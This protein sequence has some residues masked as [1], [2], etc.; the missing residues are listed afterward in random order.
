[1]KDINVRKFLKLDKMNVLICLS[2]CFVY[3][4][5]TLLLL[6]NISKASL[7]IC[8]LFLIVNLIRIPFSKNIFK[9]YGFLLF[10][11]ISIF[12]FAISQLI[13]NEK[14]MMLDIQ[15]IVA[16]VLCVNILMMF[17]YIVYPNFKFAIASS[18]LLIM[19]ITT[20]NYFVYNFRG[21]EFALND[22]LTIQTTI[23]VIGQYKFS[24]DAPF[25]YAWSIYL[26]MANVIFL[27]PNQV[28]KTSLKKKLMHF[29]YE[30]LLI[31]SL[32]IAS[33][34]ITALHFLKTGAANNGYILNFILQ[35]KETFV[36][37]P[38]NYDIGLIEK[39]EEQFQNNIDTLSSNPNLIVIMNESFADFR[40]LGD[41][42]KTNKDV[43]P[44]LDSLNK[45]TIKGYALS[46]IYGG[47]TPNSEYEFLTGNSMAF[48]PQGSIV[49]Q[50]FLKKNSYSMVDS[51][52]ELGYE[53]FATHPYYSSGW[54]RTSVYNYLGFEDFTFIDDYPQENL[55][56][57]FVSDQEMY[58][59]IIDK[60]ESS[61]AGNKF[62]FGI[63]MQNHGSY[64][65]AGDNFNQTIELEGYSQEYPDVEQYLS[66]IHE[67]DKALE[68]L[69][70]YFDNKDEP[71]VIVFYG[72]HFPSLNNSFYEEVHGSSFD[73]LDE[74]MLQYKVPFLIWANYDIEEEYVECTSLN[75]LSNYMFKAANM[76]LPAYN[77]YL[78][79]L[80]EEISAINAY[81][82]YS[83][84]DK[85]FKKFEDANEKEK[86]LLDIYQILQYNCLFDDNKSD[87]FK[88]K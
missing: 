59:Y 69:I 40:V 86:E 88:I 30:S 43:T 56:R 60:Y 29:C 48:L 11:A 1:M 68:Y 65:Y 23:N 14:F 85:R 73:T 72:D 28:E 44:F 57:D 66:L 32:A 61:D 19:I 70:H 84:E 4:I 50:Q 9:Y 8:I 46:S 37:K 39:Y 22:I 71:V 33:N 87:L 27:M 75:Y 47:R 63:T 67:S 49:Y 45:D 15:K 54:M 36:K 2:I 81:G 42:F 38:Q 53:C 80:Q 25:L 79:D 58:E 77:Q 13:L 52:N 17:F 82:F 7:L 78:Q 62:I 6:G 55:I 5:L 18:S 34:N 51:L 10:L 24:V 83:V 16:N 35:F 31:V 76:E 74:Q 41:N 64:D 3:L 20:I 12:V 26:L 21:S